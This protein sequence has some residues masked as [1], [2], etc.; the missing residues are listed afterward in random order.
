MKKDE[1]LKTII[2]KLNDKL[3]IVEGKRDEMALKN[4]GLNC[5]FTINGKPLYEVANYAIKTKKQVVILTDFDRRGRLI[6][7]KLNYL[8]SRHGKRPNK[9][10][11]CMIMGL[12]KNKIEDFENIAFKEVDDHVKIG[13]NINKIRDKSSY[14]CKGCYR[15]A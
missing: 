14:K 8:L 7:E 3:I 4:L 13:S 2:E 11:R 15:K 12:G 6:N 5:I 9:R 10:L 1:Y